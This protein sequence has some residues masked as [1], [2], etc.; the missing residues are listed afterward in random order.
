MLKKYEWTNGEI[1]CD[2]RGVK[3]IGGRENLYS[4]HFHRSDPQLIERNIMGPLIDDRCA[5]ILKKMLNREPLSSDE[6]AHWA[7]FL[8]MLRL[9]SPEFVDMLRTEGAAELRYQLD[10]P[11]SPETISALG[12]PDGETPRQWLERTNPSVIEDFGIRMLPSIA[13]ESPQFQM[14]LRMFWWLQP[15]DMASVNLLTCDRPLIIL[16]R[17]EHPHAVIALPLSPKMAFMACHD[18]NAARRVAA[19]G[20]SRLAR[21]INHDIVRQAQGQIYA[22]DGTN[23]PLIKRHFLSPDVRPQLRPKPLQART[24]QTAPLPPQSTR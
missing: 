8:V 22:A 18:S 5:P 1:R 17:L 12:L 15:F 24:E 20:Q 7:H 16:P 13:A 3:R 11:E 10:K 23:F 9:R 6:C 2:P 4:L 21:C 14:I 19:H